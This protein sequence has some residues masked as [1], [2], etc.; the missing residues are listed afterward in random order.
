MTN[1]SDTLSALKP[2]ELCEG[3]GYDG[4]DFVGAFRCHECNGTGTV[5]QSLMVEPVSKRH[6]LGSEEL[7]PCPACG[8]LPC[9][10]VDNPHRTGQLVPVPSVERVALALINHDQRK[11]DL[12]MVESLDDLR[13]EADKREEIAR[14]TAVIAAMQEGRDG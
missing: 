5:K 8:A 1:I 7:E 14:A 10:W 2:C 4:T 9:D 3:T 12:P 13:F 11:L 6:K